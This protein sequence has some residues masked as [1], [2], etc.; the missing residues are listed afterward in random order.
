MSIS[1]RSSLYDH[2]HDEACGPDAK[3]SPERDHEP[4]E[5]QDLGPDGS[6][7]PGKGTSNDPYV[8]NWDLGEPQNPYNWTNK[9]KWIITAQVFVMCTMGIGFDCSL[10]L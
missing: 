8:V 10:I 2:D 1:Q 6:Y 7:F 9:R 3:N 5:T 4:P